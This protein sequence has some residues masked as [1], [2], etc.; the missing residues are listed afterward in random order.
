MAHEAIKGPKQ[1]APA[2]YLG[3]KSD[4]NSVKQSQ[5]HR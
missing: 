3:P 2:T 1:H 4:A 5:G